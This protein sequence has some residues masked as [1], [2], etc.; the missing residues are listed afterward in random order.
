MLPL[1]DSFA[2]DRRVVLF[3]Q[4]GVGRSRPT[5]DCRQAEF[6][7]DRCTVRAF[8]VVGIDFEFG[9]GIDFGALRQQLVV[10]DLENEGDLV[11][12]LARHHAQHA[13]GARHAIAAT[14]D[15]QA[16]DVL[17]IEIVEIR[18]ERGGSGI[19]GKIRAFTRAIATA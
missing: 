6:V 7:A 11:R 15:G 12:V 1:T 2:R 13:E 16:N 10:V 3:D 19:Q 5:L 4:R 14:F 18:S 8:D 17:G 9:L